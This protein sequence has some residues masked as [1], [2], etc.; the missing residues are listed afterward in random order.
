MKFNQDQ[1]TVRET[2]RDSVAVKE[3]LAVKVHSYYEPIVAE[4]RNR[5]RVGE[6][7]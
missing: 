1:L 7:D 6:I 5:K 4:E 3:C 2:R